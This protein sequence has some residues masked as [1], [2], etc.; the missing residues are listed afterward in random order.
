M[1]VAIRGL[2]A[3]PYGGVFRPRLAEALV[4]FADLGYGSHRAI[5]RSDGDSASMKANVRRLPEIVT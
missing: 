2:I 1:R 4:A 5:A 3:V